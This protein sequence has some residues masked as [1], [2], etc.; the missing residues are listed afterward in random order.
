[1]KTLSKA[2]SDPTM[3]RLIIAILLLYWFWEPLRPVRTVTAEAL[4]T[5][6]EMVRR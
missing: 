5:A 4:Y 3:L 1:M 6:A 2:T